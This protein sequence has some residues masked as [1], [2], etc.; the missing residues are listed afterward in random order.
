MAEGWW[1]LCYA[2]LGSL[3]PLPS[4]SWQDCGCLIRFVLGWGSVGERRRCLLKLCSLSE[5]P[6][7]PSNR[8]NNLALACLVSLQSSTFYLQNLPAGL[9]WWLEWGRL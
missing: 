9:R 2:A 4:L 7:V 5:L 6:K 3:A 1:C 8:A